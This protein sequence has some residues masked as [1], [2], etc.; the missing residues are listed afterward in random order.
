MLARYLNKVPSSIDALKNMH[1]E[2]YFESHTK[3]KTGVL[4]PNSTNT[5]PVP[6]NFDPFGVRR[7]LS[8]DSLQIP[9]QHQP[10][11]VFADC[12]FLTINSTVQ[13]Q[14]QARLVA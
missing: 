14:A 5:L 2:W 8:S 11:S 3:V 4:H 6:L 10:A 1:A 13:L 7:V 9:S 12:G